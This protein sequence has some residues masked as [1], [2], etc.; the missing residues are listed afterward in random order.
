MTATKNKGTRYVYLKLVTTENKSIRGTWDLAV[1]SS[2]ALSDNVL[3]LSC[4]DLASS[5]SEL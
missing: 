5:S 4:D 3:L 1:L 2:E